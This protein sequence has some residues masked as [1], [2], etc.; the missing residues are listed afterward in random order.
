MILSNVAIHQAIDA[1]DLAITPEPLPRQN[2]LANPDESPYATTSVNLRL[3]SALSIGDVKKPFCIDLRTKGIAQLLS[4]AYRPH[5]M[6][7]RGGFSLEPH[8]FVLGKTLETVTLP[9]RPERPVYAA[10]VE[11]RSSF[12]RCGLLIHFTAPTIHAGWDGPITF[13]IMNL[14]PHPIML[15]PKMQICQ[16]IFETV[17]GTPLRADSQFQGQRTP[18]GTK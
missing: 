8:L 2:S 7:E 10:R 11:G 16:L 17:Q 15:F 1:G 14:G 6:D 18:A 12:A 13:E 5:V 3:D 9:I 4:Q